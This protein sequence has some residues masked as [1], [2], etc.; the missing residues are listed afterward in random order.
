M[1]W[2]LDAIQVRV[3]GCLIEKA[4]TTPQNYPLTLNALVN[5]CNQKS[6]RNP[7]MNLDEPTV[8]NALE[9]LGRKNLTMLDTASG[10]THKYR[11]SMNRAIELD[12]QAL[13]VLAVLMLRGEQT[14]GEIRGNVSPLFHFESLEHGEKALKRLM[15]R[16]DPLAMV[17]PKRPGQKDARYTHLLSGMPDLTAYNEPA[18][19]SVLQVGNPAY[20]ER[21]EAL[22]GEV[23][24][25]R[26]ELQAIKEA[27]GL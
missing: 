26:Q 17:L 3:L 13:C 24:V 2:K 10:R 23:A 16:D 14:L 5:A 15:D 8:L 18:A 20:E 11:Q 6:S 27:L 9:A 22:E 21:M 25:L 7:V 19:P 1:E 4:R 12:T